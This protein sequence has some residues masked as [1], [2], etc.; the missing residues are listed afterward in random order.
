MLRALLPHACA[1][2]VTSLVACAPADGGRPE[3]VVTDE[4]ANDDAAALRAAYI[5]AQA[6]PVCTPGEMAECRLYFREADGRLHCPM[7]HR[8]CSDVGRWLPCGD[9]GLSAAGPSASTR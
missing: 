4:A 2:L 6:Q 7:S 8:I 9:F 3:G 1:L 5:E